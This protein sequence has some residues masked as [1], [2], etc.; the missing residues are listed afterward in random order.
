MR[1]RHD[2]S[3]PAAEPNTPPII[4]LRTGMAS[5]QVATVPG[6]AL[7]GEA[8]RTPALAGRRQVT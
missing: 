4:R 5:V 6:V 2:G 8:G 1:S 3:T 7:S